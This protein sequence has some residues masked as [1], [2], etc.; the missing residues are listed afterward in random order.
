MSVSF[1]QNSIENA[2]IDGQ[3]PFYLVTTKLANNA[4]LKVITNF[5]KK[6]LEHLKKVPAG[7]TIYLKVVLGETSNKFIHTVPGL[8]L[9]CSGIPSKITLGNTHIILIRFS[10]K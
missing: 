4:T 2:E 8:S 6:D 9:K 7:F 5:F 1:V 10:Q 3:G